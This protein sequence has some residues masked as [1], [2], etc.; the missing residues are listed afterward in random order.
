MKSAN[1]PEKL[2]KL[3][4]SFAGHIRDPEG[5]AAPH[6]VEDRRMKIYRDLFFS[7]IKNFIA[8]N[9][10]VL[11]QLYDDKSW[12]GLVREF[13]VQHRAH[14]PLFPELP[15]EFLRYVQEQR[16]DRPGDPPFLLELAH[17]EWV[18]LALSLDQHDLEDIACEKEGDLVS[19]I[20]LLSP[21]AWPLTYNFPVH[22]IKPGYQPSKA[23]AEATHLLVYR[24]RADNV[25]FMQLNEVTRLLLA[26]MQEHPELNGQ[27][28]LKLTAETIQHPDHSVVMQNGITLM[29]D[30]HSRDVLLGTRQGTGIS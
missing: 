9:F 1:T 10:P 21:L 18:E 25:R 19:G 12:T 26:L 27:Q 14:T 2:A 17:Y 28:L 16:A 20:P 8:G 4:T 23:P 6:D 5:V 3:Q 15:K 24:N 29:Q 7:N 22:R 11:R 30:L 13:Y